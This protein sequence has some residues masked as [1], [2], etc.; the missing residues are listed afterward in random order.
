MRLVCFL[1]FIFFILLCSHIMLAVYFF[2]V[3]T[4]IR[5]F[6]LFDLSTSHGLMTDKLAR[7][8]GLGG[9]VLFSIW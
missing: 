7:I 1:R 5:N 3:C 6:L 2:G 4:V 9:E 8:K